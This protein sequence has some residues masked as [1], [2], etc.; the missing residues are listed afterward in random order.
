MGQRDMD[1]FTLRLRSLP[2]PPLRRLMACSSM[3][4]KCEYKQIFILFELIVVIH[5]YF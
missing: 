3:G 5:K 1:L 2:E 4:R